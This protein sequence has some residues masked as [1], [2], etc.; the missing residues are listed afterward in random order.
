MGHRASGIHS[1]QRSALSSQ[2]SGTEQQSSR[3][4]EQ[5]SFLGNWVLGIGNC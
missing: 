2:R 4:A 5:Q 1:G 3:A